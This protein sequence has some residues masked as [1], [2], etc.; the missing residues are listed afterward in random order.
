MVSRE[1]VV[2]FNYRGDD[3]MISFRA[4]KIPKCPKEFKA[5]VVLRSGEVVDARIVGYRY[6]IWEWWYE[7]RK[8]EMENAVIVQAARSMIS[9]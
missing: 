6:R 9:K 7:S 4:K 5:E 8:Q 3:S 1:D 2:S